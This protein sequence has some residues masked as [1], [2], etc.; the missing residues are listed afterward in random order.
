MKRTK[1]LPLKLKVET[2]K[3]LAEQQLSEAAGGRPRSEQVSCSCFEAVCNGDS[4]G[5]C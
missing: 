5:G 1:K 3:K 2:V 4:L